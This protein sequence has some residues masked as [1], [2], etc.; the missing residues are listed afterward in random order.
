MNDMPHPDDARRKAVLAAVLAVQR[1]FLSPDE[2]VRALGDLGNAAPM[3]TLLEVAPAADRAALATQVEALAS[4]PEAQTKHLSELGVTPQAQS[5]LFSVGAGTGDGSSIAETLKAITRGPGRVTHLSSRLQKVGENAGD[6]Q[7]YEIK[8][9]Y[10]RG[11]MGRILVAL[12][13]AVGREVALKELLSGGGSTSGGSAGTSAASPELVERFVRE[14]K[15]TG[16]LEHPNIVPVY[17]IGVRDD[18]SVFYTMKLIRGKTLASRLAVIQRD[19]HLTRQQKLS[20]R[21]KLLDPFVDVCNAVAYAHSR[22]VVH[23]DLKPANIMLGD[24]GE[25]LVLD[26]GLARVRGHEERKSAAAKPAAEF[27]PSLLKDDSAHRT[28]DGAVLG[29]PAYMPPEQARGE[30][31]SVDEKSDVY[32]LGAILYEILCGQA[33]FDGPSAQTVLAKVLITEPEPVQSIEPNAPPDL[34]S[35]VRGAMER[36]P[37]ARLE[38]AEKLAA[39]LLAFR[40]GRNLSVYRYS[41]R[42]LLKRFVRRH[43]AAVSVAVMAVLLGVAGGAYAFVRL[44]DERDQARLNLESAER[45]REARIAAEQSQQRERDQLIKARLGEIRSQRK[46]LD[47]LHANNLSDEAERRIRELKARGGS[48]AGLAPVDRAENSR[49][50]SELLAIAAVQGELIRLETA[51]VAGSSHELVPES[52][53]QSDRTSLRLTRIQA[54]ELSLLNDDFALAEFIVGGTDTENRTEWLARISAGRSALLARH[55]QVIEEALADVRQGLSRP[56]RPRGYIRLEDFVIQLSAYRETQTVELLSNVLA[57]YADRAD[58]SSSEAFWS[59]AERDE[60]TLACRVLGYLELPDLTVPALA[61][62]MSKVQDARLAIECGMALCQ[63]ASPA[64]YAPLLEVRDRFSPESYVWQRVSR[65]FSRVPEPADLP[66]PANA[67]EYVARARIRASRDDKAGAMTYVQNALDLEPDYVPALV[68]KARH[69]TPEQGISICRRAIG[70]DPGYATAYS[71]LANWHYQLRQRKEAIDAADKAVELEPDVASHHINLGFYLWLDKQGERALAAYEIAAKLNPFAAVIYSNRAAIY[72]ETG[73][74]D[75]AVADLSRALDLDPQRLEA[76]HNRAVARFEGGD[77]NG[78]L[79]DTNRALEIGP[80][81]AW[82]THLRAL[83][84][85]KMER[86]NDALVDFNQVLPSLE[87]YFSASYPQRA[88]TRLK[89]GD[90]QGAIADFQRYLDLLP[91]ADDRAE[92]EA[93]LAALQE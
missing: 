68:E 18:G 86:Y 66:E 9:E 83:I 75:E 38:S 33:P 27:S 50:V 74:Y 26:W 64:A 73:R 10:A 82:A 31:E 14:A 65:W 85:A 36:T 6:V 25:T 54:A 3:Q 40:D 58:S 41:S 34:V 16:Q 67:A 44:A 22:G 8:R 61:D 11:G 89:L 62:F 2:A 84:Y 52:V 53:L 92:I 80:G 45:E 87:V 79:E 28:L 19:P 30:L 37:S 77:L 12:D 55:K 13:N 78:A 39:E 49:I 93:E 81:Y 51:P 15:V 23:R 71:V 20:E 60:I 72:L 56:G 88:R 17:E 63:T 32:A 90:K 57:A 43:R 5:T 1:G 46:R 76:W 47:E 48:I 42:E 35:L 69:S 4:D 59:Q 29:T 91:E 21:L 24:F 7:R 70:L